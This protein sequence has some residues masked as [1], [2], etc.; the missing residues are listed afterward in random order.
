MIGFG[1]A[2]L[3]SAVLGLAE[4]ACECGYQTNTGEVWQF[5][6]T[7]NFSS[8]TNFSD[9]ADWSIISDLRGT[10]N[11]QP[12]AI[13][14]TAS[15]VNLT[16]DHLLLTCSAYD[17]S[18][19]TAVASAEIE[20]KRSDIRYGSFRAKYTV[21]GGSGAVGA[22]FFYA[23]DTQEVDIEFL[24]RD[25]IRDIRFTNQPD[26]TTTVYLP[27]N[28]VRTD[29]HTYRLDWNDGQTTF[30]VDDILSN[31]FT[32][33]IPTLEGSVYMNMWANGGPFAGATPPATD[34][35]LNVSNIEL[36]FNTSSTVT[37]AS[38][39]ST[40]ASSKT[41]ACQVDSEAVQSNKT[42]LHPDNKKSNGAPKVQRSSAASLAVVAAALAL[43]F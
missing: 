11:T 40:C 19:D 9:S 5:A 35:V 27:D 28:Y 17:A 33:D 38:W 41:A 10:S 42:T 29:P 15:N 4:A 20:T 8:I 16:N 7:T 23:N 25:D 30:Y 13:N 43:T 39:K 36:Y 14:Y 26:A 37:A 32:T 31:N 22:L 12:I 2:L 6:I 34:A 1:S 21:S 24:T 18:R 3:L